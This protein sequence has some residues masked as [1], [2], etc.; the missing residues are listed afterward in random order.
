MVMMMNWRERKKHED[1]ECVVDDDM[2][3]MME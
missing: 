1:V 3:M 2:I